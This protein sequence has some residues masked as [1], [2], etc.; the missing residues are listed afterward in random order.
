MPRS[1]GWAPGVGRRRREF[2]SGR[3]GGG[4]VPRQAALELVQE[5]TMDRTPQSIGPDFVAPLG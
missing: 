1:E 2:G 3:R 5:G 4:G